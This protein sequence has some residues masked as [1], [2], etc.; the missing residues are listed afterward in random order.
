LR[1]AVGVEVR[2]RGLVGLVVWVNAGLLLSRSLRQLKRTTNPESTNRALTPTSNARTRPAQPPSANENQ[3]QQLHILMT[4][5]TVFF[6][7]LN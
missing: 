3:P 5:I 2:G 4:S 7:S 1:G 6:L